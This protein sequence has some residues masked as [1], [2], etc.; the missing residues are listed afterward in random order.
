MEE[1]IR[2][3]FRGVR[4]LVTLA[5]LAA[6]LSFAFNYILFRDVNVPLHQLPQQELNVLQEKVDSVGRKVDYLLSSRL[7]TR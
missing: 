5:L 6:C 1:E 3:H 2:K 4:I 7:N